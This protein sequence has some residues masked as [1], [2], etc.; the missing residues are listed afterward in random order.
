MDRIMN[1]SLIPKICEWQNLLEAWCRVENN[2]GCAGIDGVTI[3]KFDLDLSNNLACIQN[4]LMNLSYKP[5]A[6]LRFYVDKEDTEKRPL[7]VPTIRDRVA[8]TAVT[9]VLN[10]IFE[11]EFEDV[12]FAYRLNKSRHNAISLI[13]EWRDRGYQWVVDADI[14]SYFDEVNHDILIKRVRE[15]VSDEYVINLIIQWITSPI[16]D[17]D[18]VILPPKGLPQGAVISPLLANLYLDRFD[19]EM[20]KSKYK[21]V[22]YADDFLVL[23]KSKPDAE[24]ALAMVGNILSNLGLRLNKEKTKIVSFDD[25]FEYLGAIFARSVVTIPEPEYGKEKPPIVG[26]SEAKKLYSSTKGSFLGK[27]LIDTFREQNLK[28]M[29][30]T[31]E[32]KEPQINN[33]LDV[34]ESSLAF[35]RTLYI[36][37]Q[38]SILS[39]QNERFIVTKEE[40]IISEVLMMKVEQIIIFGNCAITTPAMTTCLMENIPITFLS[41]HGKYYGRL[42]STDNTNIVLQQLQFARASDDDFCLKLSKGFVKG[43]LQNTK[44]FLQR[45][46]REI[47]SELIQKAIDSVSADIKNSEDSQ[48]LDQLRGYEGAASAVYFDVF[49]LMLKDSLGFEKRIRQPPTDPIN[50]LLSFG[51]TLLFYNIYSLLTIHGLNPYCGFFHSIREGHPALASDLIEEFRATVIDSLVVYLINSGILKAVDF[52]YPKEPDKPCLLSN[53]ARKEFIKHFEQKMHTEITHPQTGFHTNYRRCIELQV[54]ELIRC[55]KGEKEEYVPMIIFY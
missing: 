8:Q 34:E 16:Y 36:Q 19:E 41:S 17:K 39:K 13:S 20:K 45:R 33:E 9:L 24:E 2:E 27:A 29:G 50:S 42:E 46:N 54:K 6:L 31:I 53:T 10:P 4:E 30:S 5:D 32:P 55:I 18:G 7:S 37:T 47:T 35:M 1:Q 22:R 11:Q 51:Y 15:L 25:G 14:D 26:I 38:G 43:K 48:T 44:A 40:E 21:L 12:S 52:T 49:D 3:D 28:D 23:C